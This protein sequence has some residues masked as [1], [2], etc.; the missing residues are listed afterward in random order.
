MIQTGGCDTVGTRRERLTVRRR[1]LEQNAD[2]RHSRRRYTGRGYCRLDDGCGA[3]TCL[4]RFPAY[5]CHRI[6]EIGTVGVGE[7]TDSHA[8]RFQSAFESGRSRFHDPHPGDLQARYRILRLGRAW[9][10]LHSFL[11]HLWQAGGRCRLPSS[12]AAAAA[13]GRDRRHRGLSLPITAA[14][15][16]RFGKPDRSQADDFPYAFQ[17]DA[18]LY[19]AYLRHYAEARGA[20]R[21][22]GKVVE[23]QRRA[24]DGFIN[25]FCL[26]VASASRA[27]CS[28]TARAF[29]ACSLREHSATG[30]TIG[31]AFCP[32]T[33]PSWPSAR[34]R[35]APSPIP[36]PLPRKPA[37]AG[38]SRC[39]IASATDMSIAANIW[40]RPRPAKLCL[41]A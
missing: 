20:R 28:S 40:A 27:I 9:R 8:S 16:G 31:A 18:A 25:R 1:T 34:S 10:L 36:A 14:R 23:V 32:A 5:S 29:A 21:T 38:A 26:T 11:W 22:E 6:R 12:L 17:F 3:G 33:A 30:S 13:T 35:A 7:S 19:A 24:T 39:N 37:G 4:S 15:L 41:S 2:G